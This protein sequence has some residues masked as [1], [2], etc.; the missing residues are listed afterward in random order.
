MSRYF[1][2]WYFKQQKDDMTIALIAGRSSEEAF[3]QVI[4]NDESHY[5]SYPLDQ[6][7]RGAVVRVG[8]NLFSKRGISLD[9]KT[10]QIKLMGSIRF[11]NL[12][13]LATDIMGPFSVLPMQCSH[14]VVSMYHDLEGQLSLR[15]RIMD[16]SGG[17]GYIEG[18][19]GVSFPQHY[20][21]FHCNDFE[22]KRSIMVSVASVPLLG[23]AF[24]G[25]ICAIWHHGKEYRLATYR[26]VRIVAATEWRIEL[27]QGDLRLIVE[28]EPQTGYQLAAP[29]CG[30]MRRLIHDAP[31]CKARVWFY[32][33]GRLVFDGTS[34]Q[35]S[36]EHVGVLQ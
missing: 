4:T 9:L 20:V 25:C 1:E 12:T 5:I 7:Q 31:A 23:F 24:K 14:M 15:D 18:D 34:R 8:G 17:I 13:P 32:Q 27:S 21:W 6:Y 10:P 11:L 16:F 35:A 28:V 33:K 3:V 22:D 19:R 26:G 36:F 2:G 30:K 29:H